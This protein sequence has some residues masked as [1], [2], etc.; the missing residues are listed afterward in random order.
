MHS[1]GHDAEEAGLMRSLLFVPGDSEKKLEKGFSAQAD[2]VIVD[3]EDS[4]APQNKAVA[5]EIAAKSITAL[6]PAM[7]SAVYVRV[8]DLS[9]GLT[10]D[11][12]AALIPA[13]PD[14]IMLPKSNSGRDAQ[15]LSAKL[16]VHEAENGLPDGGI[17]ILP[18]ITETAI[19]V[20]S[21]AS[22]SDTTSRLSGLTWG[23]EDLSA[24][25]GARTP[26]DENGR[27]T[28]VFRFA[29]TMTILAASAAEV[30]AIDTVFPNFRDMAAF[31]AE[32]LEAERDGFT[33]KMAIHPAQV[34]VI[35]AAFTPTAEAI[36]H[37][38]AIVAAFATAGNPGV[39]GLDGK[40]VDRPHLKLAERLLARAK[41][42]GVYSAHGP[43]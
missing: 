11:D 20:L 7:Q 15:Q 32:C 5:R 1:P 22:Y 6:R 25:I 9:T 33:G 14:G 29:R 23:A 36:Q 39:V 13:R 34:P 12:L 24:A 18:I 2:V 43:E 19:G 27:Y 40:M 28:D 30:A 8:N 31:E 35:N 3:L 38:A 37:S 10:D 16:R 4:V 42:A 26:R 21:A 17:K 41:A